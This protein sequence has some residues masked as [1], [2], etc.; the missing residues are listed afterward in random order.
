[1]KH[2]QHPQNITADLETIRRRLDASPSMSTGPP[3][4]PGTGQ[5]VAEHKGDPA[6]PSP[7]PLQSSICGQQA[8]GEGCCSAQEVGSVR[9]FLPESDSDLRHIHCIGY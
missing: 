2:M 1:M 7:S 5:A 8:A 3:E 6:L 9:E 4:V